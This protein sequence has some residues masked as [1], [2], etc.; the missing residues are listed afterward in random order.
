M[1]YQAAAGSG[2]VC[3]CHLQSATLFGKMRRVIQASLMPAR[4]GRAAIVRPFIGVVLFSLASRL[5]RAM[6]AVHEV[7]LQSMR[8]GW[9]RGRCPRWQ[10][11]SPARHF[12]VVWK[13][14]RRR[15]GAR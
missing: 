10:A 15:H 1:L 4:L 11:G 13:D 3:Y 14:R 5:G 8:A 7:R 12:S 9:S 6:I 2:C